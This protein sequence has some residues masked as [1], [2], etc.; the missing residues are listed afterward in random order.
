MRLIELA[1]YANPGYPITYT[2]VDPFE[3]RQP[4]DGPGLPL[5]EAYRLLRATGA[6]IH[7]VPGDPLEVFSSKAN[8]LGA[9]DLVLIGWPMDR[10]LLPR[11]SHYLARLIHQESLVVLEE[12]AQGAAEARLTVLS[13]E[14][15]RTWAASFNKAA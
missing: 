4:E 13:P 14:R 9:A 6:R 3:S 8:H 1:R 12:R 2:A 5:R 11:A 10:S 7:L 15:I